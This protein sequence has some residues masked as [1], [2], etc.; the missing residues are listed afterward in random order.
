MLSG[1]RIYYSF[2]VS[3]SYS[4]LTWRLSNLP[5]QQFLSA[6]QDVEDMFKTMLEIQNSKTLSEEQKLLPFWLM[7]KIWKSRNN[8]T[9]KKQIPKSEK[10]V[11]VSIAEVRELILVKNQRGSNSDHTFLTSP[12]VTDH[13]QLWVRPPFGF[14]ECNFDAVFNSSS[15]Q[16]KG[17][18]IIRDHLGIALYWGCASLGEHTSLCVILNHKN[19]LFFH[20]V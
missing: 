12:C 14:V 20:K 7:W 6:I 13:H 5:I 4:N 8:L 2:A 11:I 1:R 10:D 15:R 3:L 19:N 9:F 16:V 17:G 18:W